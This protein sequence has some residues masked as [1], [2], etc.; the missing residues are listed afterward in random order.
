[1][2]ASSLGVAGA[3][4]FPGAPPIQSEVACVEHAPPYG[5]SVLAEKKLSSSVAPERTSKWRWSP[6]E[7]PLLPDV[8]MT[9]PH[10][11]VAPSRTCPPPGLKW[12]YSVAKPPAC[13]TITWFPKPPPQVLDMEP[14]FEQ[15]VT[16]RTTIPAAAA[17]TGVPLD[18]PKSVPR[19][20]ARVTT[21]QS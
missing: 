21:A 10:S 18:T 7:R 17:R 11:T 15:P 19:W 14:E 5:S 12:A 9:C 8:P 6:L 16:E 3:Q 4:E 20:F 1:M 2:A 13:A